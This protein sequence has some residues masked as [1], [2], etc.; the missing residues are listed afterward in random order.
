MEQKLR[1]AS[2]LLNVNLFLL[3][4]LFSTSMQLRF[5]SNSYDDNDLQTSRTIFFAVVIS[6]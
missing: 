3:I 5:T 6:C 2:R 4:K 1:Q